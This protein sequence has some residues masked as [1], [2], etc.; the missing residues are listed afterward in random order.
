MFVLPLLSE[1][2]PVI[3]PV[4]VFVTVCNPVA[5]LVGVEEPVTA[6]VPVVVLLRV[7]LMLAVFVGV[8]VSTEVGFVV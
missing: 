6:P 7:R 5:V 3:V 8:T 1:A 4:R 2:D